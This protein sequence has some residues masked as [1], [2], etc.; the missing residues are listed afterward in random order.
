MK[1]LDPLRTHASPSRS[2]VVLWLAASDPASGS[3][4]AQAPSF[5][6][7]ARGVRYVSFWASLPKPFRVVPAREVW[8]EIVVRRELHPRAISSTTRAKLT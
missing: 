1:R 2:A 7:L 4:R 6:P 3:V 5:S 8:T